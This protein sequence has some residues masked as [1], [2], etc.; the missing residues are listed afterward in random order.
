MK[1]LIFTEGTIIMHRNAFG[2]SQHQIIEQ[3]HQNE[4]SIHDYNSYIPIGDSVSKISTWKLQKADIFYMT[5]RKQIDEINEINHVLK[6]SHFPDGILVYRYDNKNY[7]DIAEEIIPDIL[8]EDDCKSIGGFTQT[9]IANIRSQY[10]HR[11]K[12][13]M[14]SEF[15]G[16]DHLPNAISKLLEYESS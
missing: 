5:S 16:I 12:G 14:I 13:I 2:L 7:A 6:R 9:V 4:I 11:I 15:I 3:V 1:I 10:K 8:I